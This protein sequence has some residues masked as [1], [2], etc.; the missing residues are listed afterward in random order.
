MNKL[1]DWLN[2]SDRQ[3]YITY[4][5]GW[6]CKLVENGK[7]VVYGISD[8]SVDEAIK[9]ALAKAVP[10]TLESWVSQGNR[11]V[12][13]DHGETSWWCTLYEGQC[14]NFV[15]TTLSKISM[16]DAIKQVLAHL[17]EEECTE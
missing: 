7:A 3:A 15:A 9:S 17:K 14:D 5:N 1:E 12:V 11:K 10:I 13:F 2:T 4:M 16:E 8:V 6:K